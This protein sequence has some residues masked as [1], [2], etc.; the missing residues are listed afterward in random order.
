MGIDSFITSENMQKNVF[1]SVYF[2]RNNV[3]EKNIMLIPNEPPSAHFSPQCRGLTRGLKGL[4][5]GLRGF[6]SDLRLALGSEWPNLGSK[7]SNL[8]SQRPNLRSERIN[9]GFGRP[10]FWV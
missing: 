9:L 7:R 10:E 1:H 2:I 5:W 6:I 3:M 8:G 4:H